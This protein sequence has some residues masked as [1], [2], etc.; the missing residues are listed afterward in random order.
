VP[1]AT[2]LACSTTPLPRWQ[3]E[4]THLDKT[5]SQFELVDG[6]DRKAPRRTSIR[7]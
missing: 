2:I 3:K 7:L 1:F 5:S 6:Y 4:A